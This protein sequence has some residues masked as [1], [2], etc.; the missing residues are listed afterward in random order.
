VA[1]TPGWIWLLLQPLVAATALGLAW[2]YQW[3]LRL[4]PVVLLALAYH[5]AVASVHQAIGI[6][7]DQ[8]VSSVYP[9]VGN[10]LLHGSYPGSEYPVGAVL[11]FALEALL[12]GG[13]TR[14]RTGS[15]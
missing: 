7:G 1:S 2:R 9:N 4:V 12:G 11:L 6:R 15:R 8:D 5:V 3:H 10:S 14:P 13:S